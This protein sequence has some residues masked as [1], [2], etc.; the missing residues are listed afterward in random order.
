MKNKYIIIALC[1]II[2]LT[3]LYII[4]AQLIQR[5]KTECF[6]EKTTSL[7]NSIAIYFIN[8]AKAFQ[9]RKD[10]ETEVNDSNE[11]TKLL[12]TKVALN[13]EAH[14]KLSKLKPI[15]SNIGLW[16]CHNNDVGNMW[17][18]MK[19]IAQ[20]IIDNIIKEINK[21]Q[22]PTHPII[23]FR[24]SDVPFIRSIHYR[25]SKHSFYSDCIKE[26]KT[27]G[28]NCDTVQIMY[29]NKHLSN[30]KNGKSCDI[31]IE[32]IKQHLLKNGVNQVNVSS[33]TEIEDFIDMYNAPAVISIGSSFSFIAGFLGKGIFL[34]SGH[35]DNIYSEDKKIIRTEESSCTNDVCKWLKPGYSISHDKIKDYYDADEVIKACS[36]E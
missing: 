4:N 27:A 8:M 18:I 9:E 32:N 24:C 29:S 28:V 22:P 16:I 2:F 23:H 21:S 36:A 5:N 31:F 11:M 25:L 20:P 13:K 35:A 17:N 33:K 19:P 14:E 30:E 15:E 7:G 6:S 12:P 3:L 26:L 34:S 10:F 1:V